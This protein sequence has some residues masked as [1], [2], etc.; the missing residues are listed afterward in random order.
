MRRPGEG[1][2]DYYKWLNYMIYII[3]IYRLI[4]IIKVNK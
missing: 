3:Y 2:D 4:G 1:M